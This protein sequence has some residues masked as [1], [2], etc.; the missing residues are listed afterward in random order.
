MRARL[1]P[2]PGRDWPA[3]AN[4]AATPR[5]RTWWKRDALLAWAEDHPD[6]TSIAWCDDDLAASTRA[7]LG[8]RLAPRGVEV[9]FIAPKT[10]VGLT[11]EHL[12]RLTA[13]ATSDQDCTAEPTPEQDPLLGPEST[14]RWLICSHRS[15]HI[16]DLDARTYERRPGVG[17]Q[18]FP[19]D[20]QPVG[21]SRIQIWPRIGG[22]MMIWFDDPARPVTREHYRVSSR[23]RAITLIAPPDGHRPGAGRE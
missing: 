4:Q 13:W 16:L 11:P 14:G 20:N 2:F 3:I 5:R 21:Y 18:L 10:D 19:Y 8:R 7:A 15:T 9:L 23:I 22:R 12:E 1:N 17:S 6:V